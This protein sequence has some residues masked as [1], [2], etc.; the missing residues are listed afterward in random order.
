MATGAAVLLALPEGA[1]GLGP[2]PAP[3]A[4]DGAL[5]FSRLRAG[6]V[7]GVVGLAAGLVG[8]GG[9]FLLV[10]LLITV[11]GVPIRVTIGSSLAMTALG[12]T[13]GFLGKLLTGQIPPGP[14]V[15]VASGALVGAHLGA[16]VSRRLASAHLR[17]VLFAV[18]VLTA[19]RVWWD[20]LVR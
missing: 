6:V 2:A 20:V 10:P 15:A 3:G 8:A 14:A 1:L 9:A 13:A 7:A 4:P 19:C 18:V 17:A 12:A 11:V 5:V 16:V